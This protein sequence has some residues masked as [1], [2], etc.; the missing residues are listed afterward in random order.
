MTEGKTE[1]PLYDRL[2]SAARAVKD[3][4]RGCFKATPEYRDYLAAM[5]KEAAQELR[6]R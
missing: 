1:T 3:D 2:E 4:I 6:K 5:L